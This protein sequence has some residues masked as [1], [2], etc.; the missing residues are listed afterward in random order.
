MWRSVSNNPS[1]FWYVR[2]EGVDRTVDA[3][4]KQLEV[5]EKLGPLCLW[6]IKRSMITTEEIQEDVEYQC[7]NFIQPIYDERRIGV[8][9]STVVDGV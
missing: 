7:P 5:R 8:G 6:P 9:T 3:Y 4:N 1:L 2:V